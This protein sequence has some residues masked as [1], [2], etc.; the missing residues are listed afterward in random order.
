MEKEASDIHIKMKLT[1]EEMY[2]GVTKHIRYQRKKACTQCKADRDC[3]HCGGAGLVL[4]EAVEEIIIPTGVGKG[5]KL[6]F[7][8]KGHGYFEQK[9]LWGIFSR[10]KDKSAPRFG[11]LI[12][13]IEEVEHRHFRKENLDLIYSCRVKKSAIAA[14]DQEIEFQHL[15]K[16]K[17][18][19]VIPQN[20]KD[21]K[22]LRIKGKGFKD[23]ADN[24]YGNLLI[25]L[26]VV[27]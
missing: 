1:L 27:E 22:I 25:V 4:Q 6:Q 13:R 9:P 11:N 12:L 15:S 17:I 16:E 3:S 7:K 10:K 5:M 18:R 21:G 2:A 23:L 8:D 19:A 14:T 26:Q 24:S 20:A